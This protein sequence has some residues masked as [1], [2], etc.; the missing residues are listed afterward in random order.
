MSE[1]NANGKQSPEDAPTHQG[2]AAV[3]VRRIV[4][5]SDLQADTC[6]WLTR[7]ENLTDYQKARSNLVCKQ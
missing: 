2:D 3:L 7:H 1:S 4:A 6:L 5:D